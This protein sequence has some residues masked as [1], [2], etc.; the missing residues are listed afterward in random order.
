MKACLCLRF[1]SQ[2]SS[3]IYWM[4]GFIISLA[5]KGKLELWKIKI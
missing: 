2:P 4:I 5:L 1:R 3:Y